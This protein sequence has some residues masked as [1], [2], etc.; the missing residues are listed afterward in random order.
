MFDTRLP[1]P[2]AFLGRP[3]IALLFPVGMGILAASVGAWFSLNGPTIS[4]IIVVA[5]GGR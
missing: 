4:V 5:V 3:L 2:R 1:K